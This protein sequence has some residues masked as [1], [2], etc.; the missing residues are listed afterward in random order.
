MDAKIVDEEVG[1]L[2]SH[3]GLSNL[4]SLQNGKRIK[5]KT[6]ER[7]RERERESTYEGVWLE[8]IQWCSVCDPTKNILHKL[9][10]HFL[11][12]KIFCKNWT[13]IFS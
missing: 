9:D 12:T 13:P 8:H 1:V 4:F 7:E 10:T 5:K 11:I 6:K 2:S 3:S